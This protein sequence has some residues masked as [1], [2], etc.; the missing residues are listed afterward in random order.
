MTAAPLE[1]RELKSNLQIALLT[2]SSDRQNVQRA[3]S[4]FLQFS[5]V[6]EDFH[7]NTQILWDVLRDGALGESEYPL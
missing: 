3:Q 5:E 6:L 7:R 1:K 2:T 4:V